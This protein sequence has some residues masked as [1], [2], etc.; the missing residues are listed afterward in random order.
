MPTPKSM[1]SHRGFSLTDLMLGVMFTGSIL[2]ILFGYALPQYR[3]YINDT[4]VTAAIQQA[5]PYM[6]TIAICNQTWPPQSCI[7]GNNG[8][9][10]V[11]NEANGT[12]IS[13]TLAS[14]SD[15]FIIALTVSPEGTFHSPSSHQ[16]LTY[17]YL[18]QNQWIMS[19][20]NDNIIE[21]D[22]CASD[23]VTQSSLW[24][25]KADGSF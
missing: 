10:P 8:I 22:L 6:K 4:L 19:C 16:Y 21:P 3:Q 20:H 24:N 11:S 9:P 5:N 14:P 1:A 15:N 17:R 23:A 25:G 13:T 12:S 2:A 18:G 7:P